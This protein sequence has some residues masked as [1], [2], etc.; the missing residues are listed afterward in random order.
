[1]PVSNNQNNN[2]ISGAEKEIIRQY[3]QKHDIKEIKFENGELVITHNNNNNETKDH[4]EI[5]HN[6]EL[7]KI[8]EYCQNSGNKIDRKSLGLDSNNNLTNADKN[9]GNRQLVIGLAIGAG[10]VILVGAVVYFVRKKKKK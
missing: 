3:F 7:L 4:R 10:I 8:M 1:V 6:S 5:F 2:K 9:K